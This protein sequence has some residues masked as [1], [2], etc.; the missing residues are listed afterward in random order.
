MKRFFVHLL[1][2]EKDKKFYIGQTNDINSRLN[3][4]NLGQ[5]S[6]TKN[7]R[8]LKLLGYVEVASRKEALNTEKDLKSHSDKKLKFIQKF[9]SD[10]LWKR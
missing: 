2:S 1:E 4:H 9:K 3:K 8:P 5:V 6:S 10:F 7:R